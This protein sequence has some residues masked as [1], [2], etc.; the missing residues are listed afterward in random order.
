LDF[1]H[2]DAEDRTF[3]G[4]KAA[5]SRR[6]PPTK[7]AD[8]QRAAYRALQFC[9]PACQDTLGRLLVT[10]RRVPRRPPN[11]DVARTKTFACRMC[12]RRNS[13]GACELLDGPQSVPRSASAMLSSHIIRPSTRSSPSSCCRHCLP[14]YCSRPPTGSRPIWRSY[15]APG[16]NPKAQFPERRRPDVIP[17]DGF[18]LF[19]RPS[20]RTSAPRRRCAGQLQVRAVP[21]A[22]HARP[23]EPSLFSSPGCPAF[24]PHTRDNRGWPMA[25][26]LT[27]ETCFVASPDPYAPHRR[28]SRQTRHPCPPLARGAFVA[29]V[30]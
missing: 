11:G 26:L 2:I 10:V 6:R 8:A 18:G 9:R 16:T 29:F 3:C 12:G 5:L 24:S 20:M 7:G 17:H 23:P 15:A 28:A 21:S 14:L 30:A 22:L 27:G 19:F 25:S 13:R 1:N 4:R